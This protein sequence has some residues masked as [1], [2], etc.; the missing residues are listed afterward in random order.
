MRASPAENFGDATTRDDSTTSVF[1]I[2]GEGI[3]LCLL[4]FSSHDDVGDD[5]YES[6]KCTD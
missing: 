6:T 4:V 3:I 5:K 2:H 1:S